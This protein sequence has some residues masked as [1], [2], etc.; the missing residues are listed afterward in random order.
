MDCDVFTPSLAPF[1]KRTRGPERFV[2]EFPTKDVEHQEE[3]NAIWKTY[4][5]PTLISSR[6]CVTPQISNYYFSIISY[7]KINYCY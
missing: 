5:T 4:L 3:T 7:I 2:R 1:S 6:T